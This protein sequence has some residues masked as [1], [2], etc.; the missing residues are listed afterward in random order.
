LLKSE[1]EHPSI[2]SLSI[3]L[4]N[5]SAINPQMLAHYID[6]AAKPPPQNES[7]FQGRNGMSPRMF[8]A[9]I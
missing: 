2:A 5:A 9:N 7:G 1:E 4:L 3:Q 6:F 8:A